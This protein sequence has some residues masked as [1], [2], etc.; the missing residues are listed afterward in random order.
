MA[1]RCTPG[2]V[3]L[4]AGPVTAFPAPLPGRV[5]RDQRTGTERLEPGGRRPGLLLR[6]PGRREAGSARENGRW[7]AVSPSARPFLRTRGWGSSG[8]RAP[9]PEPGSTGREGHRS[10]EVA[11]R[12]PPP[13]A[14][15]ER[16]G[17]G[18]EPARPRAGPARRPRRPCGVTGPGRGARARRPG[19]PP[20][21]AAGEPGGTCRA[22]GG[23]EPRRRG[24][25]VSLGTASRP[26]G[27][28]AGRGPPWP[29]SRA[30]P[31]PC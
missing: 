8:V 31:C 25:R 18:W 6:R 3:V 29:G 20:G 19:L 14:L 23:A 2:V 11:A 24:R 13:R 26:G 12:P 10:G 5:S 21:R 22:D 27:W 1:D 7:P 28:D 30:G 4:S 15:P 17:V 16:S 9:G